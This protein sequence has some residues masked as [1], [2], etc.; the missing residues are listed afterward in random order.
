MKRKTHRK[1]KKAR[2]PFEPAPQPPKPKLR[3]WAELDR[4]IFTIDRTVGIFT[5]WGR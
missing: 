1:P 5:P 2:K 3:P 4:K